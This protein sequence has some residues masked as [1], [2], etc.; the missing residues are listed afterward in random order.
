MSLLVKE[1]TFP[2]IIALLSDLTKGFQHKQAGKQKLQ[3]HKRR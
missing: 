1:E 3:I 2:Q